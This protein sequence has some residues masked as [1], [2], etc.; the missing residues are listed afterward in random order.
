[1]WKV[2]K[3]S[4]IPSIQ[5]SYMNTPVNANEAE[6]TMRRRLQQSI[7][8]GLYRF[9]PILHWKNNNIFKKRY[10]NII[11]PL[12]VISEYPKEMVSK[13]E[14]KAAIEPLMEATMPPF[15]QSFLFSALVKRGEHE[16]RWDNER[17]IQVYNC[18]HIKFWE[19]RRERNQFQ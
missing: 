19:A 6:W 14:K 15:H 3:S 5:L 16:T 8:S 13:Y 4:Y 10:H 18:V 2:L 1:M 17:N 9:H 11:L 12:K 7:T